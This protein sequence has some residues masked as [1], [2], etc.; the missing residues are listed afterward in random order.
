MSVPGKL[1]RRRPARARCGKMRGKLRR[2]QDRKKRELGG[3][4]GKGKTVTWEQNS[5]AMW[6]YLV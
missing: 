6:G 2:V 5:A 3:E 4:G 1:K